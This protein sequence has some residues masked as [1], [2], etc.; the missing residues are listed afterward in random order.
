MARRLQSSDLTGTDLERLRAALQRTRVDPR[1]SLYGPESVTWRVNREAVLLLGGGRALLMQVAHPLVAAGVA[2]HSHFEQEPLTRLWR[3]LHLSLTTVFGDAV[4]ALRA[5]QAIERVHD[6]VH[7]RLAA[8]A[9]SKGNARLNSPS[10]TLWGSC[11]V[12]CERLAGLRAVRYPVIDGGSAP[13]L[14]GIDDR[15]APVPHSPASH[16]AHDT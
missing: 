16:P 11:D 12:G 13:V 9:P 7:G 1:R 5:V 3:T 6:R 15:G 4:S 14:R 8:S 10:A 2:A